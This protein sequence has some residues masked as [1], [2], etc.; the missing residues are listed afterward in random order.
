MSALD[1]ELLA[2]FR[3]ASERSI[4]PRWQNLRG[5]QI[6]EKAEDD[7]VTIVDRE[8]EEFLSEAL[9]KLQP[10][11]A[12]VGEEAA[13]A[14][15]SVLDALSGPCW[16]IDPIDG[17]SNFA[18]GEGHFAIMLA[19]ADG[20]EAIAS[21]IYDPV[22][23]RLLTARKGG[24]AAIDGAQVRAVSGD[25]T[26]PVLSAMTRYMSEAQR[27]LFETE[28]APHYRLADAPGAAA[29]EYP[30]VAVG[31]TD[32]AIYERTLPWDHAAGSLFLT[33][34]GGVCAR[35]DGAPYRVDSNRKGMIAAADARQWDDFVELLE[36]T[37]FRPGG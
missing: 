34:A 6:E 24:G 15:A 23:P 8:V 30:R 14:D 36:R 4:M 31:G 1:D 22:R 28:I 20:G 3:F 12:I 7:L 2:L 32:I 25:T 18:R 21:W 5:D 27:T 16:I 9:A 33:E 37:G 19:L 17:T 26:P 13:H 10:G 29:E 11:V 35:Q